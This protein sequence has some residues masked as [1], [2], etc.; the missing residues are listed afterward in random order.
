[1]LDL[2][3]TDQNIFGLQDVSADEEAQTLPVEEHVARGHGGRDRGGAW[4]PFAPLTLSRPLE[5]ARRRDGRGLA[6]RRPMLTP[7]PDPGSRPTRAPDGVA[8]APEPDPGSSTSRAG[9]SLYDP[10]ADA[11]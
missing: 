9:C 11:T 8:G 10:R 2:I 4:R 3:P 7:A 6:A 5:R 1:M